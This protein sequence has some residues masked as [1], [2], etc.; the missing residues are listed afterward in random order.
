M[1]RNIKRCET[2][3]GSWDVSLSKKCP[4]CKV[5]WKGYENGFS[6]VQ[7]GLQEADVVEGHVI[8]F[9]T[10]RKTVPV[11]ITRSPESYDS[12]YTFN[13]NEK[14]IIL[15]QDASLD[16]VIHEYQ[17]AVMDV[18]KLKLSHREL[19]EI[20]SELAGLIEWWS[21]RGKLT[22]NEKEKE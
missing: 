6:S 17:E 10:H 22:Y 20:A 12:C 21:S 14:R 11:T 19:T 7:L 15:I 2:C 8:K 4:Y 13:R 9:R 16:T 18:F 5:Y 3:E 1:K